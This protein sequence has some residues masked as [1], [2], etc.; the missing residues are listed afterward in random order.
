MLVSDDISYYLIDALYWSD[1]GYILADTAH[2]FKNR[3]GCTR[4][5]KYDRDYLCVNKSVCPG[6]I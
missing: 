5:F 2:L 4:W 3:F 6:H 1:D